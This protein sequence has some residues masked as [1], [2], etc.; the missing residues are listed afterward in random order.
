MVRGGVTPAPPNPS[1]VLS[2]VDEGNGE[3]RSAV[4]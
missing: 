3:Q 2:R 4:R 1:I